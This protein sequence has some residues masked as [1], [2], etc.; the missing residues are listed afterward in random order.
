[1]ERRDVDDQLSFAPLAPH[2]HVL[3]VMQGHGRIAGQPFRAGQAWFVPAKADAFAIESTGAAL[4]VTYPT[5]APTP[6]FYL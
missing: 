4:L 5:L 6:A 2:F 1:M 3:V